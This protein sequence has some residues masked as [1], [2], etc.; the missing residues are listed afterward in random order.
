MKKNQMFKAIFVEELHTDDSM[1]EIQFEHL[2]S[3][4]E[5]SNN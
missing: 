1:K 2:I 5:S 3:N 4:S